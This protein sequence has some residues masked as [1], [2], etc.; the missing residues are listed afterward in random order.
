L[1]T[2][3]M[4]AWRLGDPHAGLLRAR[5]ARPLAQ[6]SDDE[7][8]RYYAALE[9]AINEDHVG[10]QEASR[11]HY[12]E[13]ANHARAAGSAYGVSMVLHNLGNLELFGGD[14]SAAREYLEQA[15]AVDREH[16]LRRALANSVVDL[17]FVALGDRREDDAVE[18]FAES[19][20]LSVEAGRRE[21]LGWALLGLAATAGRMHGAA[22]AATLLGAAWRLHE[23]F[24]VSQ[25]YFKVGEELRTSTASAARAELGDADFERAFAEGRALSQDQAVELARRSV[26]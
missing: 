9:L 23:T 26:P 3:S 21:I 20:E 14:L 24:G 10:D 25:A 16:D 5:E 1:W 13:A 22:R 19:L 12:E 15:V 6:S 8:L 2:C 18:H 7:D 17:G 11:R 4:F